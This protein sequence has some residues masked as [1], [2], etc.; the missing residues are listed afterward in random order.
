[1]KF[2]IIGFDWTS[3]PLIIGNEILLRVNTPQ[4]LY[5]AISSNLSNFSTTYMATLDSWNKPTFFI[6]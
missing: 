4:K 2:K 5:Q 3:K 1:M 6:H